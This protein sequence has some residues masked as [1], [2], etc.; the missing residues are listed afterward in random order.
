MQ[1]QHSEQ[2]N[3]AEKEREAN[4]TSIS[5]ISNGH[6]FIYNDDNA[7]IS[8]S[9]YTHVNDVDSSTAL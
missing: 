9:G 2:D 8:N 7:G 3:K 5:A 6:G 1:I 4:K